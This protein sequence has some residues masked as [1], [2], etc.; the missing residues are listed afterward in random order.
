MYRVC[1]ITKKVQGIRTR[2]GQGA[3]T[4]VA[5]AETTSNIS[6]SSNTPSAVVYGNPPPSQVVSI[7]ATLKFYAVLAD[8]VAFAA[9]RIISAG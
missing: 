7:S 4:P 1:G 3:D 2:A 5:A 8:V 9:A 6:I